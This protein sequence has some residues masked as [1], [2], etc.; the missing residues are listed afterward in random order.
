[1][2]PGHPLFECV[3]QQ[4]ANLAQKDLQHGAVFFDLQRAQPAR[5]DV[6]SSSIKDGRGHTL[7]QRLFAVECSLDGALAIRQPTIFLDLVPAPT[8]MQSPESDGLPDRQRVEQAL[9]E[10][11]L[12]PFLAEVV[13]S[14]Q[15]ELDTIARHVDI[16]LNELINRQNLRM[17]DLWQKRESGDTDP[18]VA[19]NLKT[20]ED[21]IDELNARLERRRRDIEQ[22]RHCSISDIRHLGRAW[23]LPHPERTS[24]GMAPMVRDEEIERMAIQAAIAH[25]QGRGWHVES[26]ENEDRGFDLISRRPHPEDPLTAIEV[27]FIEVKG[28][29]AVGEVAMSANE[30]KTSERLRKDYWLYAVFNCASAPEVHAIQDPVRLGWQP[31]VAV[32]HYRLTW[33]RIKEVVL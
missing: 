22:E 26:V 10:T 20:T 7:H 16:S 14:R 1:M 5:L 30:Y 2:T 23:V 4:T 27:R 31:V 33:E 21:R 24:P 6:F 12:Q 8:G 15:H 25:E 29:A 9:V 17:A 13:A 28:R 32:E 11:A 18:L 3:R 19:A